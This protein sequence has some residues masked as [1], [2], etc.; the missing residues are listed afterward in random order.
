[1]DRTR[2]GADPG[3]YRA[4]SVTPY[5]F[6]RRLSSAINPEVTSAIDSRPYR[7]CVS[8]GFRSMSYN[9]HSSVS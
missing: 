7:L 5:I 3:S 4:G 9:S 1:M 8:S 2:L 6:R